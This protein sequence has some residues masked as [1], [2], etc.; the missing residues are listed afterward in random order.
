MSAAADSAS[1]SPAASPS[2]TPSGS[3]P[4]VVSAPSP[5]AAPASSPSAL[6]SSSPRALTSPSPG[7][8]SQ[9][10]NQTLQNK[11]AQGQLIG[12]LTS[13]ESHALMLERSLEQSQLNLVALGQQVLD[14]QRQVVRLDSRIADVSEKQAQTANRLEVDRAALRDI[15]RRVYKQND[16]M[17]LEVLRA[18]GFQSFLEGIGYSDAVIDREIAMVKAVQ[19]DVATLEHAQ[20][21]LQ[22]SRSEKKDLLGQ[23]QQLQ[24][25][26][27][28]QVTVEQGLQ[29]QLQST[30]DAALS[31]LDAMQSDTPTAAAERA[32]LI[33]LKTDAVLRQIEQTV[34]AQDTLLGTLKL[35]PEDPLL[36]STGRLLWPIPHATISQA[37]GP[38]PYLFEPSFAGFAHFHTGLDLAVPLGTPV[39]AAADGAV[40]F[41]RGMADSTGNLI[42]YGNYILIQHDA[43]LRTLYGHLMTIGVKEGDIVKRGQLIGLVG[44]TGNSTGP[45]THFEVRLEESPIDPMNLL[46]MTDP[47]APALDPML[48]ATH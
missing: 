4:G 30:I 31:A 11:D 19:G 29:V 27:A 39:F 16:N 34:W 46:S 18:G 12:D 33:K 25:A 48:I 7:T 26:V 40:V 5:S 6:T 3:P 10:K 15:V 1:P 14:A 32:K 36:L 20:T 23:L 47:S 22:Q 43:N 21:T 13:A 28:S 8:S 38:T 41:A 17:F 9:A 45:H 37:F 2:P 24:A 42:G 35:P 44:S